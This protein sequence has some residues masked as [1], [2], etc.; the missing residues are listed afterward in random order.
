V[1]RTAPDRTSKAVN[2]AKDASPNLDASQM[3]VTVTSTWSPGATVTVVV[4]Y[5]EDITIM[6]QTLFHT[7]LVGRRTMRVEQ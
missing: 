2:A 3:D 7:D 4:R 5:P 1:S 6:G